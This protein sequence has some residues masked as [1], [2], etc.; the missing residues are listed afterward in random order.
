MNSK[1]TA[2]SQTHSWLPP[3]FQKWLYNWFVRYNPLYFF[4]ALCVLLGMFLIS[5][6]LTDL[7]WRQWQLLLAAIMQAYEILL[8]AGAAILFRL[9]SQYRPAVILGVMNL[10]FLFDCTFQTEIMTSLGSVSLTASIVWVAM[11][12]F[13]VH[14]L[15]WVF[16]LKVPMLA[17]AVPILAA[18][19]VAGTPYLL[20]SGNFDKI[21]VHMSATWYGVIL[22]ASILYVKPEIECAIR[23]NSWGKTV[24]RRVAKAALGML[25]G[26]YMY[27]L[28]TWEHMYSIPFTAAQAAPFFLFWFLPK[29]EI[30]A[31]IGSIA[32]VALSSVVPAAV[33]PVSVIVGIAF[34]LKAWQSKQ[35][36]LYVGTIIY[37]YFSLWTVGWQGGSL[38]EP[39]LWLNLTTTVILLVLAWR[40]RLL[41]ALFAVALVMLPGAKGWIPRTPLQW[42]ILIIVAGFIALIAGV[43]IN[44]SLR[45]YEPEDDKKKQKRDKNIKPKESGAGDKPAQPGKERYLP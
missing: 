42:G 31:W 38:P 36:R 30:W 21:L 19:G 40:L 33:S 12:A 14:A 29:K 26:L 17:S 24:L 4:S 22:L 25:A 28:I 18:M 7:G 35:Y 1:N 34:G 15:K 44:W 6:E 3:W 20:Y 10:F 11:I 23:L 16:R 13:K 45:K 39:K 27:H 2:E 37:V 32:I 41:P 43:A 8:I 9:A 5:R